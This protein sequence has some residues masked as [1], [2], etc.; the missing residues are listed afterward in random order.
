MK[1][2]ILFVCLVLMGAAVL[3]PA[4]AYVPLDPMAG[5]IQINGPNMHFYMPLTAC[6]SASVVLTLFF[7]YMRK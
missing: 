4:I 1:Q 5:D 2:V 7:W 3:W 6:I